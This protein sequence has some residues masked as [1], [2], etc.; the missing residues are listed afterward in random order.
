MNTYTIIDQFKNRMR[1]KKT[2]KSTF[3]LHFA[4]AIFDLKELDNNS[5]KD[6][7]KEFSNKNSFFRRKSIECFECICNKTHWYFKCFYLNKK[8]SF[9]KWKT[10]FEIRKKIQK[11][12]KEDDFKAI[13]KRLLKKNNDIKKK[14]NSEN[15]KTNL[16]N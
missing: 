3:V 14:K 8:I 9:L 10:N 11:V 7:K 13:I 16:S 2:K 5:N 15:K 6:S 12:I 4:F 1:L